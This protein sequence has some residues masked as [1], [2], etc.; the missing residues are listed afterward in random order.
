MVE[1]IRLL[2]TKFGVTTLT[3]R[4]GTVGT[5]RRRLL[6]FCKALLDAGITGEWNCTMKANEIDETVTRVMKEAGCS[7]VQ[8]GIE[9]GNPEMLKKIKNLTPEQ[10]QQAAR[11]MSDAGIRVH[12]YFMFGL[13][14]ETE[15]TMRETI[16]F[17]CKLPLYSAGFG[18]AVPYPGTRFF[19]Y[20]EERNLL[21]TKQWDLYSTNKVVYRHENLTD[22]QIVKAKRWGFRHFYLRPRTAMRIFRQM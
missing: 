2:N 10:V 6:G 19:E 16:R 20:C 18:V 4:D 13:P 15:E 9:V 17:A 12:G 1:E 11:T 22:E 5:S 7:A 21:S 14:G 8:L 3:M